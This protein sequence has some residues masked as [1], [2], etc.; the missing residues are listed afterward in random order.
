MGRWSASRQKSHSTAVKISC[1]TRHGA[2]RTED[3]VSRIQEYVTRYGY[4]LL[5]HS[6]IFND[7]TLDG[8]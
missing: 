6:Q 8:G 3:F 2:R 7:N 1:L 5:Y 4:Y